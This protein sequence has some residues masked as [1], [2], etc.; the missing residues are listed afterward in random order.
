[1]RACKQRYKIKAVSRRFSDPE[2]SNYG[3]NLTGI[4]I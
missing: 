3:G 2:T 4:C 1:M